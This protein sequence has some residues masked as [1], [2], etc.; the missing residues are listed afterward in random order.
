[1]C[2]EDGYNYLKYSSPTISSHEHQRIL[3]P[4]RCILEHC[5]AFTFPYLQLLLTL[6]K[7]K[8]AGEQIQFYRFLYFCSHTNY[9]FGHTYAWSQPCRFRTPLFVIQNGLR[10]C[11]HKEPASNKKCICVKR[12]N[13]GRGS[14]NN[15]MAL[16]FSFTVIFT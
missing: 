2:T 8:M 5:L 6:K 14:K 12:H 4:T 3:S 7:K 9:F 1:M 10:I 16:R 11:L 15:W 13:W